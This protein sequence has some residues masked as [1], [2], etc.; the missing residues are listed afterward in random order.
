MR[1]DAMKKGPAR[2]PARAMLR[3]TGL[4]PEEIARPLVAVVHSWTDLGPCNASLRA[5][6]EEVKAGVREAGGTPF[7]F[8]TIAISDGISM[9][10]D[11][12]RASLVS[13]EVIADSIE[14]AVMGHALDAVVALS[15]CDKTIPGSVMALARLDIPAVLLYGGSILPGR[16]QD[17]DV[18]IQ[19]VF[20]AIGA[21]EAGDISEEELHAL[22]DVASPGPGACAGL[23]TA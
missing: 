1:S 20:E 13:R 19:D 18:T 17:R 10:T 21:Y 6:A 2:A 11:G 12:M 23:F 22:E 7:E 3:A 9:G 16:Y 8:G 5:L 4:T 14:L 15:G